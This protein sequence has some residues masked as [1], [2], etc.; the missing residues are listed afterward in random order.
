MDNLV[1]KY[2]D[3]VSKYRKKLSIEDVNQYFSTYDTQ[4]ILTNYGSFDK[5]IRQSLDTNSFEKNHLAM[6]TLCE[7]CSFLSTCQTNSRAKCIDN[8]P[9]Q[10]DTKVEFS[11]DEKSLRWFYLNTLLFLNE[12]SETNRILG[13]FY[14]VFLKVKKVKLKGKYIIM[15][16]D[17]FLHYERVKNANFLSYQGTIVEDFL[18]QLMKMVTGKEYEFYLDNIVNETEIK[19]PIEEKLFKALDNNPYMRKKFKYSLEQHHLIL[20]GFGQVLFELDMLINVENKFK[21]CIE[22]DGYN[23]HSD[24]ERFHLDRL[25]DRTLL[26]R[27]IYTARFTSDDINRFLEDTV[28]DIIQIIEFHIHGKFY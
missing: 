18:V 1:K 25:R 13:S 22:C 8:S 28:S 21:L 10:Y 19:S 9:P 4:F 14:Q 20:D 26:K 2:Q 3:M 11:G 12:Y 27:G 7:G 16:A 24:P 6:L 5:F 23:Y 15:Y 17:N